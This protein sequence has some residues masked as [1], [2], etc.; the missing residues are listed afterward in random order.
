MAQYARPDADTNNPGSYTDQAAGSTDI[1]TTI[2]EG[3]GTPND[4][5][6]IQSPLVPSSAVYVCHLSNVTDP[7]QSAGHVFKIRRQKDTAAGATI[8]ATYELRQGYASEVSQGTLIKSVTDN[9]VAN[10]WSNSQ[11]TLAA[12]E[13][14]SITDY[15]ALYARIVATQ[16]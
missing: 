6:Y 2:D 1:Y 16:A 7:Q 11:T 9:N 13:A 5:D 8:N 12:G 10:G 14:D 4:S 15:T 3:F